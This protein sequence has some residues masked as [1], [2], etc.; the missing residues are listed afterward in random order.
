MEGALGLRGA[1]GDRA[2]GAAGSTGMR[3]RVR[4]LWGVAAGSLVLGVFTA[5]AEPVAPMVDEAPA[6]DLRSVWVTFGPQLEYAMVIAEPVDFGAAI[7]EQSFVSA[8]IESASGDVEALRLTRIAGFDPRLQRAMR[9][10]IDRRADAAVVAG[11]LRSV[12]IGSSQGRYF[13][14][15]DPF[16]AWALAPRVP[17]VLSVEPVRLASS[18]SVPSLNAFGLRGGVFLTDRRGRPFDGA[19]SVASGETVTVVYESADGRET[20]HSVAVPH[21]P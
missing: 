18:F 4:T 6:P 9:I 17:G 5:C 13:V 20:R 14:V 21:L 11:Q 12:G 3:R 16:R 15:G 7:P 8:R 1:I 2:V 19:L 10:E